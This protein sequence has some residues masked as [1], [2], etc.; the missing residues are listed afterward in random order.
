MMWEEM[1]EGSAF[2]TNGFSLSLRSQGGL[3]VGG[4]A[5]RPQKKEATALTLQEAQFTCLLLPSSPRPAPF[6]IP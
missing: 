2:A 3:G 4:L 1:G 6:P 5:H